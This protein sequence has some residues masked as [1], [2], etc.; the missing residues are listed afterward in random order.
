MNHVAKKAG[1]SVARLADKMT[2]HTASTTLPSGKV[3]V[4]FLHPRKAMGR[5]FIVMHHF[6]HGAQDERHLCMG[7][8]GTEV[9]SEQA[10]I[11][12]FCRSFRRKEAIVAGR[13]SNVLSYCDHAVARNDE[14]KNTARVFHA[15]A[16]SLEGEHPREPHSLS[17]ARI[18]SAC[19]KRYSARRRTLSPFAR[20]ASAGHEHPKPKCETRKLEH[21]SA[22]LRVT[23][24]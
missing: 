13:G 3:S 12:G 14:C 1:I 16:R 22:L 8:D 17:V 2:G 15:K 23:T 20:L 11:G 4:V 19:G 24:F 10:E 21:P 9:L 7:N 5:F 6:S 18:W